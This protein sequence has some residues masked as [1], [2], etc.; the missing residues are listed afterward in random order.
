VTERTGETDAPTPSTDHARRPWVAA[1]FSLFVPGLGQLYA[2]RWKRAAVA[3]VVTWFFFLLVFWMIRF[4][5]GRLAVASM[6]FSVLVAFA[7]IVDGYRCARRADSPYAPA[8]Y[9]RWYVYMGAITASVLLLNPIK[10]SKEIFGETRAWS[11]PSSSMAPTLVVGDYLWGTS[12]VPGP[13]ARG[14]LAVFQSPSN[15]QPAMKR[16]A[17]IPGDTLAMRDGV[18]YRDGTALSEAYVDAPGDCNG[19]EPDSARRNWGPL[20]VGADTYFML[21]DNRDCSFDSRA[22]GAIKRRSIFQR[23]S[24]IYFSRDSAGTQWAR[25]GLVPR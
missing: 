6:V 19:V 22:Y 12:L 18:L 20:V 5:P 25:I 4:A 3:F 13:I 7:V 10:V 8:R 9:N 16:I 15:H 17:G 21:G 24:L 14:S 11:I 2:G 23:P 1:L